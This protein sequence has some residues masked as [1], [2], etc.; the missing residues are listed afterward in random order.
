MEVIYLDETAD[1]AIAVNK[2]VHFMMLDRIGGS[3]RILEQHKPPLFEL[4][5]GTAQL[6][7]KLKFRQMCPPLTIW[8]R[9]PIFAPYCF[10][11][12]NVPPFNVLNDAAQAIIQQESL[13]DPARY[14]SITAEIKEHY[15]NAYPSAF[16]DVR[17]FPK[18]YHGIKGYFIFINNEVSCA[19][20]WGW[21]DPDDEFEI[22]PELFEENE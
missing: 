18:K 22:D 17:I 1:M 3:M 16:F 5:S 4:I 11:S 20:F 19:M 14:N 7:Y 8:S 9:F 21:D 13:S 2:M 12:F 6:K 15:E 10:M